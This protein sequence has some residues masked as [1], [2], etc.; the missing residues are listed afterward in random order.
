MTDGNLPAQ[1]R[2]RGV[3]APDEAEAGRR[4]WDAVADAFG[5]RAAAAP[6]RRSGPVVAVVVA[7]LV[8]ASAFTPPGKAIAQWARRAVV[9]AGPAQKEPVVLGTPGAM[10]IS[11]DGGLSVLRPDGS[12]R[13]LGPYD[14]GAW[15]PHCRYVVATRGRTVSAIEPDTG[16][17]RWVIARPDV[18]TSARW[19]PSGFRV[20]YLAGH[21]ELRVARGNHIDDHRVALGVGDVAPAWRPDV[22]RNV[23]A[24]VTQQRRIVVTDV[25]TGARLGAFALGQ[26]PR[27]LHW[28][29]DGRDLVVLDRAGLL[30]ISSSSGDRRRA[31]RLRGTVAGFSMSPVRREFAVAPAAGAPILGS[32]DYPGRIVR[33]RSVGPA[34]DVRFSPNGRQVLAMSAVDDSWQVVGVNQPSDERSLKEISKRPVTGGSDSA[35]FPVVRDWCAGSRP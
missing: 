19:A 26:A 25:D 16:E 1:E 2:L 7:V 20:A 30:V 8:G 13:S 10:L 3:R 34:S 11:R 15:S 33:I 32:L 29:P 28:T 27:E 12:G 31:L 21:R 23:V 4:S 6:R 14:D 35:S 17:V 9:P 24:Y 18:V 22:R 5:E